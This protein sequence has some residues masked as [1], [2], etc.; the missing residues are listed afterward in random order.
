MFVNDEIHIIL[1][2]RNVNIAN[3]LISINVTLE[4]IRVLVQFIHIKILWDNIA[5]PLKKPF[6]LFYP[7]KT[8]FSAESFH[9]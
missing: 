8:C 9:P 7:L 5:R 2:L 6:G 1:K 3:I 4:S